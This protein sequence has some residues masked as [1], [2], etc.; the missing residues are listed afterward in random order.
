MSVLIQTSLGDLT[1]DLF[2]D[3][4]PRTSENFLKL[5]KSKAYNNCLFFNVQ[6]GF[7]AQSGDPTGTG[8]GGDCCAQ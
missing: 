2:V 8:T 6:P 5:C 3:E 7:I 1:V 4:C